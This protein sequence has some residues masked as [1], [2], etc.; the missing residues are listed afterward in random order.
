MEQQRSLADYARSLGISDAS[1][2]ATVTAQLDQ[3]EPDALDRLAD[4]YHQPREVLSNHVSRPHT[5]ETFAD[6]LKRNMEGVTQH[7]LRTRAQL[8]YQTLKQFLNG[9]ML[10][11]SDQSE[12][13]ARALYIDRTE[14]ARVVT[15]TMIDRAAGAQKKDPGQAPAAEALPSTG[16]AEGPIAARPPRA[17]RP[18][19]TPSDE[20]ASVQE[21]AATSTTE[22]KEQSTVA[23]PRT[24][25]PKGAPSG[26]PVSVQ[27]A[28]VSPTPAPVEQNT[29]APLRARRP[30][31]TSDGEIASMKTTVAIPTSEMADQVGEPHAEP[32]GSG[33]VRPSA[34]RQAGPRIVAAASSAT[35]APQSVAAAEAQLERAPRPAADRQA[36]TATGTASERTS[37]NLEGALVRQE[38]PSAVV[39]EAEH[40]PA[41][42]VPAQRSTRQG[43]RP[44]AAAKLG[45]ADTGAPSAGERGAETLTRQNAAESSPAAD[46]AAVAADAPPAGLTAEMADPAPADQGAPANPSSD[47]PV[48][49]AARPAPPARKAKPAMPAASAAAAPAASTQ[50]G[51]PAAGPTQLELTADELRLIRHWRQLHPHGRRATLHYIGSLLVED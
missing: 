19:S 15:A 1:L 39:A 27:E 5:Q 13:L 43:R 44:E 11:D 48:A 41:A 3:V 50:P 10:P 16:I 12:R 32:R 36:G 47:A 22:T 37:G 38:S 25:R 31:N 26:E 49:P 14:L 20:P 8:D 45:D 4:L 7:G 51:V 46:T 2:R 24:R 23:P 34:R 28:A 18:K 42:K 29:V 33:A 40:A 9:D 35:T 30:K 6:W 21:T 17:R